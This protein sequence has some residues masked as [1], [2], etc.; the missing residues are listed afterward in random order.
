MKLKRE[1]EFYFLG[2]IYHYLIPR[3]HLKALPGIKAEKSIHTTL[4]LFPPLYLQLP[5]M[6]I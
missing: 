2:K 6:F 5:T 1:N 3:D 4:A